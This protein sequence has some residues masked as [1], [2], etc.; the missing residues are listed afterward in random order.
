ML[1]YFLN[2]YVGIGV[3]AVICLLSYGM[4]SGLKGDSGIQGLKGD[5]FEDGIKGK[6]GMHGIHGRKGEIGTNGLNSDRDETAI[7]SIQG[8]QGDCHKS[9]SISTADSKYVSFCIS[10]MH[11]FN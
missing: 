6:Q 10:L 9:T 4:F 8:I 7:Q 1:D 11:S 2:V 3:I 5:R